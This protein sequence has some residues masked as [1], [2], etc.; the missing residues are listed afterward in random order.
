MSRLP[1]LD[2][3]CI[4]SEI[5]NDNGRN[6]FM[7]LGQIEGCGDFVRLQSVACPPTSLLSF[8]LSSMKILQVLK[9]LRSFRVVDQKCSARRLAFLEKT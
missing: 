1:V 7:H 6:P 8:A 5:I 9:G 2:V 4:S 3:V